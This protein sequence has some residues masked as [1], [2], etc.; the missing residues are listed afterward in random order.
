MP[1]EWRGDRSKRGAASRT[2]AYK[3]PRARADLSLSVRVKIAAA[4]AAVLQE[5][6]LSDL[7]EEALQ[8][9]PAVQ[10]ELKAL[11]GQVFED[12]KTTEKESE[13]RD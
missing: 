2:A 7:V 5:R 3:N 10:E 8:A 11:E 13:E 6:S 9:H 1:S 12:E 4:R